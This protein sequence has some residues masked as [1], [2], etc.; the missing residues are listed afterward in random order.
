[1]LLQKP[2]AG[3]HQKGLDNIFKSMV[4]YSAIRIGEERILMKEKF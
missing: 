2:A 1:M 4:L 3:K